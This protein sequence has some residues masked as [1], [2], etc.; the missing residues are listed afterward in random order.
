MDGF[1]I[2]E[3]LIRKRAL[4]YGLDITVE[5]HK[6]FGF[7]DRIARLRSGNT[8]VDITI[9]GEHI[10]DLPGHVHEKDGELVAKPTNDTFLEQIRTRINREVDRFARTLG[11]KI[12]F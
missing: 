8:E 4:Q 2:I 6:V 1:E 11:K 7:G 9:E 12:G 3:R 5:W 10:D